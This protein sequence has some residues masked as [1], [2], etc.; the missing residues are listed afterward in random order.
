MSSNRGVEREDFVYTKIEFSSMREQVLSFAGKWIQLE[1]I[2]T[3]ELS[4][5][6]RDK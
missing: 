3:R 5:S 2:I 4:K 6:Q 1:M